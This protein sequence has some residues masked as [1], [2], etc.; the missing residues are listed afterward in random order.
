MTKTWHPGRT[1]LALLLAALVPTGLACTGR[2]PAPTFHTGKDLLLTSLPTASGRFAL[3]DRKTAKLVT[4]LLWDWENAD[5]FFYGLA[6]VKKDGKWGFVDISGKVVIGPQF[7]EVRYFY[8]DH[9]IVRKSDRWGV[10]DRK[11]EFLIQP[12]FLNMGYFDKESGLANAYDA[13]TEMGG[14]IDR[15]GSW[16]IQPQ[17][18]LA[19]PFEEGLALV[20]H[21]GKWAYVDRRGKTVIELA[22]LGAGPGSWL[23]ESGF[24][25]GRACLQVDGKWGYIDKSGKWVIPPNYDDPSPFREGLANVVVRG[26]PSGQDRKYGVIDRWGKVVVPFEYEL[27]GKYHHG[28][29]CFEVDGKYGYLDKSG[30]IVVPAIY[31]RADDFGWE[32]PNLA[33]VVPAGPRDQGAGYIDTSGRKVYWRKPTEPAP[34]K[35]E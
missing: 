23:D 35:R 27:I 20:S 29:A 30:K 10:I 24:F 21:Q 15:A 18:G 5:E 26:G 11:G 32:L 16:V 17:F 1:A 19:G 22:P 33:L 9:C 34:S 25:D 4:E 14:Y 12:R 6:A 13:E 8:E 3:I 28:R 2:Q 7:D 31:E